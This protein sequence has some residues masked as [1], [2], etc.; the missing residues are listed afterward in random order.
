MSKIG[1]L[2]NSH[3]DIIEDEKAKINNNYGVQNITSINLKQ[4]EGKIRFISK[5]LPKEY[6]EKFIVS[7][8]LSIQKSIE[9]NDTD[10]FEQNLADWEFTAEVESSPNLKK[11]ITDAIKEGPSK[12]SI[13]L[14]DVLRE[15]RK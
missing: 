8:F 9:N 2:R 3:D 10:E 15:I 11:E 6:L 1:Y 7:L 5:N 12:N 13:S 4:F 14:D